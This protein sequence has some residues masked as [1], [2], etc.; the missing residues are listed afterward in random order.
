MNHKISLKDLPEWDG[1]R[2]TVINY[3][4]AMSDLACLSLHMA[5]GLASLATHQWTNKAKSWWNS[6]PTTEKIYFSSSWDLMVLA[7]RDQYLD[8]PWIRAH[9]TE[10]EEMKFQ[11]AGHAK[12]SPLEFI[13]HHIRHH[14]ILFPNNTGRAD[15]VSRLLHS[16]PVEWVAI[17][18]T[19]SCLSV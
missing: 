11:Q 13:Q 10:W 19:T 3:L 16:Q 14:S 9:K 12:E 6:L 4:V 7:I 15:T 8:L 18:N 5:I 17:L 1:T 2:T